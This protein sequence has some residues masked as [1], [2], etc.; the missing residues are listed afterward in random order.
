MASI[1]FWSSLYWA[2]VVPVGNCRCYHNNGCL[3][4]RFAHGEV[5]TLYLS[6]LFSVPVTL[7]S[8]NPWVLFSS[9]ATPFT[10]IRALTLQ[11]V[12]LCLLFT[13]TSVV[14][15]SSEKFPLKMTYFQS[16]DRHILRNDTLSGKFIAVTRIPCNRCSKGPRS[17]AAT[18]ASTLQR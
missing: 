9:S 15:D 14:A 8:Y 7:A 12:L 2:E 16:R 13:S 4:L 5:F 10:W 11:L 18:R 1:L 6:F 3:K 17:T